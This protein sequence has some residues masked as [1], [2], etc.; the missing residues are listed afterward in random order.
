MN[1]LAI[2]SSYRKRGNTARFVHMI[3][4]HLQEL[5]DRQHETLDVETIYL[6]HVDLQMCRG[7]RLCF[8]RGELTII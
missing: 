7:C 5:A 3:E 1:I 6:A 8:D 2:V 4:A